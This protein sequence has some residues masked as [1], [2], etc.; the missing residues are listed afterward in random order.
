MKREE[1]NRKNREHILAC[2]F[3]E[4]A[5]QGYL[6]ASVNTVCS[7]GQISKGQL[8][9]HFTD[10]DELYLACVERC[11]HELTDHLSTHLNVETITPDRYFD[12]RLEYFEKHPLHQKLFCDCVVNP[13]RHL[14]EELSSCRAAFD[15]L[16]ETMLTAILKKQT[17]AEGI[18]LQDAIRQLR[19]FENLVYIYL[20]N[21]GQ[22]ARQAREHNELCRQT[23]HTMLYGLITRA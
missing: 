5:R 23:F 1:K 8:Y 22:E 10:K 12:V 11:F 19:I 21:G 15:Q 13:P 20:K 2:A 7:S 3:A 4:F 16:N 9:Y 6:G 17:L 14:Q 18:T